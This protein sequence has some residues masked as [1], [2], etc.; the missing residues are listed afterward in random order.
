LSSTAS[1]VPSVRPPSTR[2][3]SMSRVDDGS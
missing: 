1:S 2:A 3:V